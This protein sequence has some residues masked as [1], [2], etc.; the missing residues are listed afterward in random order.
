MPTFRTGNMWDAYP[1]ADLFVITTNSFITKD[2]RLVMGRGIAREACTRF[3]GLDTRLAEAIRKH[4]RHLHEYN[5]VI[6]PQTRIAAFQVKYH[7]ADMA[8]PRLIRA[9]AIALRNLVAGRP[10]HVHL[11][12]PGI[13]NGRLNRDDVLPLLI[14]LPETVTIWERSDRLTPVQT[15]AGA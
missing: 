4:C 8:T 3:P 1:T 11:N 10:L 13:G 6:D 14:D 5:L 15:R 12:F 9:S 7:W 2:G